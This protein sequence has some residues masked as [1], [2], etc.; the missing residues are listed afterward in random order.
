MHTKE[1]LMAT[2]T[3]KKEILDYLWEWAENAGDWAKF[4]VKTV[5]EKEEALSED[6][7]SAVYGEFLKAIVPK[8]D[9]TPVSIERPKLTVES[10]DLVLRSMSDIKGVNKLAENQT[11]D[12]SKNITV[13]Y[14]EN[15]SG[16][17][18][19]S[20]IL[21]ALGFSYEKETKVLRNV[22]CTEKVCQ[23]AKIDY[24]LNGKDDQ[25]K[26]H[27][28]CAS[29]DL[30]SIS[31]FTNNCVNISLDSKRELLITPIGFH[32]FSLVSNELDNLAATH[33]AKINRFKKEI[34]WLDD[35]YEGT[36]IHTFLKG[37]NADSSKEDL[38]K[39]GTY[40]DKEDGALNNLKE[41]KRNLNKKLLETQIASLQNQSRELTGIRSKTETIRDSFSSFD[42]KDMGDH[43]AIIAE[44]KKKEQKGLKEI[45]VERGIEFYESEEFDSFIK[46][47]DEYI[48]KLGKEDYPR[49]EEEI[50]IYC[51]QKLT[52][53]DA[54]ELLTSYRLLLGDPTQDQIKQHTQS[55][56]SL[57]SKLK[58][59]NAELSL[60][61]PSFGVND[62]GESVQ[63]DF[64]REFHDDMKRFKYIAETKDYKQIQKKIFDI[65]YDRIINDLRQKTE[66]TDRD[67]ESKKETLSK[68]EEKE[69]E[70]N[71][72]INELLDCKKL[73][74]K[75][76]EVDE[77]ITGLKIADILESVSRS[78][79]TDSISRKTTDARKDLIAKN[80]SDIFE[81]ELKGFRRPDIKVNLNFKTDKA[82]SFIIQDI[83]SD[84]ALSDILSEG[85]QKAI[86]LAEFLT[87]L[88]LDKSKAPVIFD[89]PVT[90]L[91]H[92]I[93]DEF[94]GRLVRL[95]QERQVIVFTHSILLFNSIKHKS[96]LPRF[97]I[98]EFKYYETETDLKH[99]GFLH[100]S[101]T[102]REDSFKNY[103]TKIN[104]LLNLPKDERDRRESELAIEGYNKLRP[105]IEV[106]VEKEMF[107][108]TVKRY[109]K[110]VAL[111]L[112]EKVN[113]SLIDKHKE[114]L[115]DIFERCCGYIDAHSSPDGVPSQPTVTELKIDFDEVCQIRSEFV[116]DE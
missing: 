68:I 34:E 39:L 4:L 26:W 109:R 110:N 40:T 10:S 7:L 41:K 107:K 38:E 100:E 33:K 92:K 17:S 91:D 30:Q 24:V 76:S 79:T 99:T 111:T 21:K 46:A 77:I 104:N 94:A 55:F 50:C 9:E 43:L 25:F 6:E 45:A 102:L 36:E 49:D 61:Y 60:H 69:R 14:G 5:V 66:A 65:N 116:N 42:W 51:R 15:A 83:A 108:E 20:R 86:A 19:Y 48:K 47:A 70:L 22:Y 1:L 29:A 75:Y 35:L 106:F 112:L 12:F 105:A 27:G 23:N 31:V 97:K 67:L 52:G 114:S 59:I 81:K 56:S 96:E 98:L 80:F 18:G 71:Q 113:G 44:L 82:K 54:C 115:N 90:S 85:E 58:N 2:T 3:S 93:V 37:L 64:L 28:A 95:S 89:D 78:F 53:K 16:K 103:K 63:P 87:E 84:Y 62:K 88:Q 57:Q 32:L 101:P 11:L 73:N 8:E 13:V 74:H 72:Q